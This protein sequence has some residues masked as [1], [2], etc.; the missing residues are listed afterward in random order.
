MTW[1]DVTLQIINHNNSSCN[2]RIRTLP[3][4]HLSE[5][6][7]LS[8]PTPSPF[9]IIL[10]HVKELKCVWIPKV[11]Y[12]LVLFL[13]ELYK[14]SILY[15]IYGYL[16]FSFNTFLRYIFVVYSRYFHVQYFIV[17]LSDLLLRDTY[18]VIKLNIF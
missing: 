6:L 8:L 5:L 15:V 9:L 7:V 12:F 17:W 3:I 13:F 4:F 2:L 11:M 10:S 18:I 16:I 14:N 1:K